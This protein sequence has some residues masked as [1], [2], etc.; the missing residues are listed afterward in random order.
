M[1]KI[2]F[3]II[4]STF[5]SGSSLEK[6]IKSV[7]SQN[8]NCFEYIVI[9][10]NSSDNTLN[11][12]KKYEAIFEEEG[13][14]FKWISEKDEGIYQAWNKGLR[15]ASGDWIGFLGSDDL[16]LPD[17]LTNYNNYLHE[18]KLDYISAK[19]KMIRKGQVV[20]EMG[21][22][23]DWP[24]FRK[25]MK[26]GHTGAFHNTAYF[27]RY[28]IFDETYKITGDYE[29]LLRAKKSLKVGFLN[30]FVALMGADG[31]SS[32]R[33]KDT[34]LEARRAK[35]ETAGRN[36]LFS[37]VEMYWILFKINMTKLFISK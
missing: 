32:S 28:G 36:F 9:D 33:V 23:W 30:N 13:I 3:S 1:N 20:R 25:E 29:I 35:M 27:K 10:G 14:D 6:T 24:T 21:Q 26:I 17:A 18:K 5:N 37:T 16:L 2:K 8:Y 34:L 12:L 31:I 15:L 7:L 19:S 22:E 11:I 4:T